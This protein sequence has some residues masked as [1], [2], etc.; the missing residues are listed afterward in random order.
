MKGR[1]RSAPKGHVTFHGHAHAPRGIWTYEVVMLWD[2]EQATLA[3]Y[4]RWMPLTR[5]PSG[6][7]RCT[8]RVHSTRTSHTFRRRIRRSAP[9]TDLLRNIRLSLGRVSNRSLIPTWGSSSSVTQRHHAPRRLPPNRPESISVFSA[10]RISFSY[11]LM[12]VLLANGLADR[13]SAD[14]LRT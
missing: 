13:S 6:R 12:A 14:C 4:Q 3:A 1:S 7:L 5:S 2:A 11:V 8:A 9:E 10:C